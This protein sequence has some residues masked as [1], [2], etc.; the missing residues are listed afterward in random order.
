M[1]GYMPVYP[2]LPA[3]LPI[4][5]LGVGRAEDY[6]A[7]VFQEL[8]TAFKK[9]VQIHNMFYKLIGDDIIE[10]FRFKSAV[11]NGADMDSKLQLI[12]DFADILVGLNAI[13]I[14]SQRPQ[15]EQGPPVAASDFQYFFMRRRK[16]VLDTMI[17]P[18]PF[19]KCRESSLFRP[20]IL[21]YFF[22]LDVLARIVARV[23]V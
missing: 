1:E 17:S 2:F 15:L 23:E 14:I 20:E 8:F 16:F 19:C 10:S 21:P 3:E 12:P 5:A 13:S 18:K 6:R 9:T 7:L 22:R 4:D 11:F